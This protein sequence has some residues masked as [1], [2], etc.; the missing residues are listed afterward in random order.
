M[1]KR[2]DPSKDYYD[3]MLTKKFSKVISEKELNEIIKKMSLE[4]DQL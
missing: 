1:E 4:N 3:K 2:F